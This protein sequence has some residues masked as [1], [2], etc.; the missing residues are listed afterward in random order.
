MKQLTVRL[1][2]SPSLEIQIGQLADDGRR[3]YFEYDAAFIERGLELSPFKLSRRTGLIEHTDRAFGR[4]PGVFDDSLP[5]GWGLALM[6]R[7]FR[8]RGIDP[9]AASPLDRLAYLGERTMG[10]LTYHPSEQVAPDERLLNL[11][12]ISKN[13]QKVYHGQTTDVLPELMRAGGSPGGARP[14]VL[15]GLRGEELISGET[16]LPEGFDHWIIKFAAKADSRDAGPMEFAYSEMARAA[17][18]DMPETRLFQTVQKTA[19][20]GVRRFDR[21]PGN[22]RLHMHT[23]G[24]LIQANFR[25]PS[26]DYADLL[27][28]TH[29]LTRNHQ[30][31][32]RA[33]RQMV[34]NVAAYNRDDHAKNFAFLMNRDGEWA[35]SPAYDLGYTPGPGGEHT[36]TVAGEG[37]EPTREHLLRVAEPV[38]ISRKE[39]IAVIDAVN[40]AIAGWPNV[41]NTAGCTKKLITT[42]AV[43]HRRL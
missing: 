5:D 4:L 11:V 24:N 6:D 22:Q 40:A 29:A 13:A 43:R 10:A 15:V 36:M 21:G 32:L 12:A 2:W 35:L 27:K 18:I 9:A 41:A 3:V 26:T 1:R 20:F 16:D 19:H 7:A 33:F 30:D 25:I 38:G 28:V 34:F 39:A 23:F 31:V 42:V 14:K 8:G 37:R 17:G